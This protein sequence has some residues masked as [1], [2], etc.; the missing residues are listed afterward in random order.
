M[1]K[2]TAID[3]CRKKLAVYTLR[4]FSHLPSIDEPYILD[5]G[6]GTGVPALAVMEKYSGTIYAVDSDKPSLSR[7]RQEAGRLNLIHRIKIIHG[8]VFNLSSSNHQFDII[9]AEGLLNVIGFTRG[10]DIIK[11]VIKSDGYII[12]H[13]ELKDDGDKRK[14]FRDN[15]LTLLN[16]IDLSPRVWGEYYICLESNIHEAGNNKLFETELREIEEYKRNPENFKS[17]YYILKNIPE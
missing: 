16:T 14:I 13:D 5:M 12:I 10:I 4:A 6:C 8:S 17:I 7:L 3:Q 15:N 2:Y 11:Q 9:L 1:I